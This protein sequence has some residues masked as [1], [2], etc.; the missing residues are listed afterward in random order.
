MIEYLELEGN[1]VVNDDQNYNME[2]YELKNKLVWGNS[3]S[4]TLDTVNTFVE[5]VI[6]EINKEINTYD[7][8]E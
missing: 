5:E 3:V 4:Y 7:I 1:I 6:D 2:A 8:K